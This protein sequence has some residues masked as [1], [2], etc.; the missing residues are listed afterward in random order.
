MHLCLTLR[1]PQ[2]AK[3]PY[4]YQQISV[5]RIRDNSAIVFVCFFN[6]GAEGFSVYR[7]RRHG[8]GCRKP[9][10]VWR[11]ARGVAVVLPRDIVIGLA[12]IADAGHGSTPVVSALLYYAIHRMRGS[13]AVS[14]IPHR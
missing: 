12:P 10:L 13:F 11:N 9:R 8:G 6:G 14:A 3:L 2:N 5:Y 4:T 1:A 7:P